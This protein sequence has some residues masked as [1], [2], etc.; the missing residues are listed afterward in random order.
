VAYLTLNSFAASLT[1][2]DSL[3]TPASHAVL[4]LKIVDKFY[5]CNFR[6]GCGRFR[7]QL[8]IKFSGEL[9][10]PS[11]VTQLEHI[12]L[13]INMGQGGFVEEF[14]PLNQK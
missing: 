1:P 14:G 8:I 7:P 12:I 13:K 9:N 10:F 2:C 5:F 4:T 6:D 3:F 11:L